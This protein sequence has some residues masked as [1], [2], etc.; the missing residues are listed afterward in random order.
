MKKR[1]FSMLLTV[2]LLAALLTSTASAGGNVGF[3]NLQFSLG[4]LDLAG[5]LRGLGGYSEGVT[6]ELSASGI[7]VVICTNQGGNESPGQN[8]SIVSADGTQL[9]TGQDITK[10]GTAPVNITAEPGPIS[11]TQGGCANDN[12][13][14]EIVFVYWT[15]A[16]VSVYDSAT[17]DLLLSQDYTCV[18][19]RDPDSVSCTPAP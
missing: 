2:L 12:W 17:G 1:I 10:N 8:P 19:T 14:A 4:S 13:T 5:T 18:T 15:S 6:V 9:I 3:K 7:P 16:T 11:A